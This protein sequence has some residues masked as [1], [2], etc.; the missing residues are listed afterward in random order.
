MITVRSCESTSVVTQNEA[1]TLQRYAHYEVGKIA[2]RWVLAIYAGMGLLVFYGCS[3]E[4]MRA[5]IPAV[6]V[7]AATAL[8]TCLLFR[9]SFK[10]IVAQAHPWGDRSFMY[11]TWISDDSIHRLDEE[12]DEF[13]YPLKKM[14]FAYR[15]GTR[16]LL[17]TINQAVIPID[18]M[19]LSET[20]RRY[21]FD[22]LDKKCPKLVALES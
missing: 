8:L 14:R 21:V 19:Q 6:A 11:T 20:D 22:L 13:V 12:G 7:V 1:C 15:A 10:A 4:D 5:A 18:L 9:L 3:R 17:C 2:M 16:I